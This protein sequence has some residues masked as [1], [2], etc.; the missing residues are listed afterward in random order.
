[1]RY[2]AVIRSKENNSQHEYS[3]TEK[4]QRPGAS[5]AAVFHKA[6]LPAVKR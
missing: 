4:L 1:M 5:W 6:K 3:S 2:A